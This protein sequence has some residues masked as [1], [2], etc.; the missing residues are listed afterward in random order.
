LIFR[1]YSFEVLHDSVFALIII[2][3]LEKKKR[4]LFTRSWLNVPFWP[5]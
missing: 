3:S 2:S 1:I 5:W 4:A